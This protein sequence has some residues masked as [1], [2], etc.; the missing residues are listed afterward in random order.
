VAL[1]GAESALAALS[2]IAGLDPVSY[3]RS[4]FHQ[5]SCVWPERN[6]YVDLWIEVLHALR[7]ESR[8]IMPFVLA[9]DFQDDQWTFLKPTPEDLFDLYGVEVQELN[10]WRPLLEHAITHLAAGRLI[11]TEADAYWL[12][13][14][15]GTDYRQ[16]HV[17]TTIVFNSLD[18][19]NQRLGYFH[20]AGYYQLE[21]EDFL[22]TLRLQQ[23]ADPS[24]LPLFAEFIG[25]ERMIRRTPSDLGARSI[26]LLRRY[27]SRRPT[28]NPLAR[29]AD[30]LPAW[31]PVLREKGMDHYHLWAFGSVRQ[32]GASLE[33]LAGNL[34]WLQQLDL[35]D[36]RPAA[37]TFAGISSGCK[38]LILKGARAAATGKQAGLVESCREMALAWEKATDQLDALLGGD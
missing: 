20:N 3:G 34:H 8:A 4:I 22:R 19:E 11:S 26:G 24:T 36:C 9:G 31:L 29:F 25:L 17:K 28:L 14:V 37:E 15:A 33:L 2:V 27:L 5:E 12:P 23:P 35:L 10:V 30:S 6:C 38:T 21:G 7:L 1:G 13:D 16:N 18:V 32:I